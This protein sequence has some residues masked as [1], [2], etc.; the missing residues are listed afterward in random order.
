MRAVYLFLLV[1]LNCNVHVYAQSPFDRSVKSYKENRLDSADYF[2]QQAIRNYRRSG[3]KDSLVL[4]YAQQALISWDAVSAAQAVLVL[5]TAM[6]LLKQ[7]PAKSQAAVAV[8]SRAGQILNQQQEFSKASAY[9]KKAMQA[10]PFPDTVNRHVV[11]L[12]NNTAIHYL[13][14]DHYDQARSWADRAYQLNLKLQ[15][16]DGADMPGVLQTN[17]YISQYSEHYQQALKEGLEL[18][19]VMQL[20]YPAGHRNIGIMHNSL[21]NIYEALLQFEEALYHRRKAVD[22]Q[23]E[24]YT[25]TRNNGFSLATAYQNLGNLYSY[26][27]EYS[28]AEQYLSRGTAMFETIYGAEEAGMIKILTGLADNKA[29]LQRYQE[30]GQLFQRAYN[31]QQKHGADDFNG[32][33]YVESFYG[34]LYLKQQQYDKAASFYNLSLKHF[35]QAGAL[36]TRLALQTRKALADVLSATGKQEDAILIYK[37]LVQAFRNIYPEGN[38][39]I[40]DKLQGLSEIYLSAGKPVQALAYSDSVFAELTGEKKLAASAAWIARLPFSYTVSLYMVHRLKVMQQLFASSGLQSQATDILQLTDMYSDFI[41]VHL[42]AFRTQA[43]LK[44]LA[45]VHKQLYAVAIETCWELSAAGSRQT[46]VEKALGYSEQSKALLMRLASNN[47]LVDLNASGA[48]AISVRDHGFRK[49]IGELNAQYLNGNRQSDSLLHLL[50]AAME[51]YKVFQDSIR[52]SGN[53]ALVAKYRLTPF[54]LAD[55]RRILLQNEETLVEYAVTGKWVFVMVVNQTVCSMKRIPADALKDVQSLQKLN[56]LSAEAFGAPAFRLYN[57][58]LQPEIGA[59][60]HKRLLIVPDGPLFYLNFDLLVS[61]K[62]AG[63]F[64]AM[65]YLIRD[66]NISYLLSAGSAIQFRNGFNQN[67]Q[68]KALLFAPVFTD[69]MKDLYR[70]RAAATGSED[71]LYLHRQPFALLAAQKIGKLIPNDLYAEQQAQESVFKASAAR[72]CLLHLGTHASINDADQLHSRLYFAQA[73]DSSGTD[74]GYLHAYEI[75][76]MQ[77]RA[78]LAVLTACETGAGALQEGEGVLSLSHSFMYAG[79]KSVIM[80]LWKIDEKTSMQVITDFYDLL[81]K[82]Y[83]KSEALR[84]AKLKLLESKGDKMA[85][86]YY[87]A[88]LMLMGDDAAVYEKSFRWYWVIGGVALVVLILL[89]VRRRTFRNAD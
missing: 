20:H 86:P 1:I 67:E 37:E 16:A 11:A 60:A 82:G 55:I 4:A 76:T 2:A 62:P 59:V 8:Y 44:E 21:G 81:S 35:K 88:G 63:G 36:Q 46:M 41:A 6:K 56:D 52:R 84:K 12:Y 47:L 74:D 66:Y 48:D 42:A 27:N 57:R 33:A 5:D 39:G 50:T 25:R 69:E 78:D 61:Q 64:A 32:M 54:P 31:L 45:A 9:L 22:I 24:N 77:L 68:Q 83:S 51:T 18:Q 19:R 73:D 40:A 23:L 87:W 89:L 85:H 26:I 79:C 70:K 75:Y 10:V 34:D 14:Q 15:G 53:T 65:Q 38:D 3:Q 49:R 17:Y 58:L 30:A 7:L 29:K 28:L 13:M 80:S 72:Y 43:S 71:Y